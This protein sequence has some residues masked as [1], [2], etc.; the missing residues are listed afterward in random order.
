M[1]ILIDADLL[2]YQSTVPSAI[3]KVEGRY[4]KYKKDAVAWCNKNDIKNVPSLRQTHPHPL[5]I[6]TQIHAMVDDIIKG[7][8]G[9]YSQKYHR[10]LNIETVLLFVKGDSINYRSQ[11]ANRATYK[12][13]RGEKPLHFYRAKTYLPKAFNVVYANGE[14][15]D[16]LLGIV[17]SSLQGGSICVSKDKDLKTIPG[18]NYDNY[19]QKLTDISVLEADRNFYTQILT[20]DRADNIQGLYGVGPVKAKKALGLC[21][22]KKQM[23]NVILGLYNEY[24]QRPVIEEV[25]NAGRLLYIRRKQGEM[26]SV[27]KVFRGEI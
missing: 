5:S 24:G 27:E 8:Q 22:D 14:E 15:T 17:H 12:G 19:K 11:F 6:K 23:L 13:T 18:L 20:G 26:W 7:L 3:W 2:L 25:N 4:F 16:D 1:K 9:F 10:V 21:T